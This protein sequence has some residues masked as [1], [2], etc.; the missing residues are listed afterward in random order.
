MVSATSLS[1]TTRDAMTGSCC[2]GGI[3][4]FSA[5]RSFGH[6]D[7]VVVLIANAKAW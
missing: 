6:Y 5:P 4:T 2:N 3:V 7:I 1:L